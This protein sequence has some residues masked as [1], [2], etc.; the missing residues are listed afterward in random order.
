MRTRTVEESMHV[1]F[2]ENPSWEGSTGDDEILKISKPSSSSPPE[3][4]PKSDPKEVDDSIDEPK[5]QTVP[6]EV[7]LPTARRHHRDH[8]LDQVLGDVSSGV[9]TRRQV[10]NEVEHGA[11]LSQIEPTSVEQA[12]EDCDWIIAMQEELNQFERR[13]CARFQANPKESHLTCVKRILR[14]LEGTHELGLW[15]PRGNQEFL[16]AYSDSDH[17][18]YKTDRKSTSG[19]CAFLG[20]CLVSCV[21]S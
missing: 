5:V 14:Y 21:T 19:Q 6:D 7:Q 8:P 20:G 12:L 15:Y 16:W 10:Q 13:L 17:A 1:V 11:F 9:R 3:E 4:T 2:D 18:I